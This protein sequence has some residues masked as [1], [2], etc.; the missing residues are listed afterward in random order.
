MF[1]FFHKDRRR[2]PRHRCAIRGT[3]VFSAGTRIPGLV[4][5]V[6]RGG[7]RFRPAHPGAFMAS[8]CAA[9]VLPEASVDCA[10]RRR[11]AGEIHCRFLDRPGRPIRRALTAFLASAD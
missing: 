5:D 3:L 4:V 7:C 9:L 2:H 10:I 8:D 1:S 6:S 11:R